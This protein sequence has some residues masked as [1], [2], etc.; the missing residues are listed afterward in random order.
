MV[1]NIHQR[2]QGRALQIRLAGE[3]DIYAAATLREALLP[4]LA[5]QH[6][7]EI[8]LDEVTEVDGAGLQLLI[9]AKGEAM[10]HGAQLQ[11][12]GHSVAVVKCLQLC[13]LTTYFGDPIL[14]TKEMVG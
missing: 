2:Q 6:E 11:L 3:L 7:I 9:A 5:Q 13:R 14:L 10:R 12:S 1:M 4:I 8:I